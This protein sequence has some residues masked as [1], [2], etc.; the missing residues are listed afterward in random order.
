MGRASVGPL[1]LP[2]SGSRHEQT[3]ART[4]R[5][6][7]SSATTRRPASAPGPIWVCHTRSA[8][9]ASLRSAGSGPRPARRWRFLSHNHEEI[10]NDATS[11]C[12][13]GYSLI[14]FRL[15]RLSE[16][17][18][19]WDREYTAETERWSSEAI[20]STVWPDTAI[21]F[22][23]SSSAVVQFLETRMRKFIAL[24]PLRAKWGRGTIASMP[25]HLQ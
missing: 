22:S 2:T 9:L 19:R 18:N 15:S 10:G 16:S 6:S 25:E 13:S 12:G 1:T 7:I 21:D 11:S 5:T 20:A 24:N 4:R 23:R 17:P 8:T 3:T 14:S